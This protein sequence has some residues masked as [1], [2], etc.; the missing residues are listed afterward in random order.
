MCFQTEVAEVDG[1]EAIVLAGL[2]P[3]G[4]LPAELVVE[5]ALDR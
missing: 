2:E 4:M 3:R 1:R 5:E